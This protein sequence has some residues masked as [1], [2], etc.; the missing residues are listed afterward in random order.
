MFTPELPPAEIVA[1]VMVMALKLRF[2][3][4]TEMPI[5]PEIAVPEASVVSAFIDVAPVVL[6]ALTVIEAA[7]FPLVRAVPEAGLNTRS[8]VVENATT[9]PAIGD[10]LALLTVAVSLAGLSIDTEVVELLSESFVRDNVTDPVVAPVP[11]TVPVPA[12]V[13]VDPAPEL[14]WGPQPSSNARNAMIVIVPNIS[15]NRYD[16][17]NI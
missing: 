12:P 7:P 17:L 3:D 2:G 1:G 9:V 6:P 14:F 11:V 13:P 15:G 8:E 16:F 4:D 5:V 10:P